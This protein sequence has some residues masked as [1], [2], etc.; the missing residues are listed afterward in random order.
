M[1]R[2]DGDVSSRAS[3]GL[4]EAEVERL[5]AL[6]DRLLSFQPPRA[7]ARVRL[8]NIHVVRLSVLRLAESDGRATRWL[9]RL[10][11]TR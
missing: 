9:V 6:V 1:R 3:T 11:P 2:G 4:I 7:R 8:I 10:R 5:A